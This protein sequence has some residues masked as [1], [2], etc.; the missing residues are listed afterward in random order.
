[1]TVEETELEPADKREHDEG[2]QR[3]CGWEGRAHAGSV[4][5]VSEG[6]KMAEKDVLEALD[7][8]RSVSR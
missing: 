6:V 8:G 4:V 2:Q 5:R 1:V 3:G 7:M